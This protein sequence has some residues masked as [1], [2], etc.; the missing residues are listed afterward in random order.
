LDNV[1]CNGT[2]T[3]IVDCQHSGWG[4]NN[5]GYGEGVSVSCII[6]R[7]VGGPSPQEGRLEVRYKGTWG[8]VCDDHFDNAAASVVCH[9]L[10][11]K[12]TGQFIGSHYGAGNGTIWLDDIRCDGMERHISECSH[13]GWGNHNCGHDE[14]VAVSC[15]GDSSTVGPTIPT[16]SPDTML[17]SCMSNTFPSTH[18][19]STN[20]GRY[21]AQIVI[22]VVVVLGL[23]ICVIVIVLFLYFRQK[24]RQER[25]EVS[26]IPMPVTTSTNG[27]NNDAFDE[28]ALYED[29][30][31]NAQASGNNAYSKF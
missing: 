21:T 14:D 20:D 13:G 19:G 7:L 8:T 1:Q 12:H 4:N 30:A 5:C 26:M 6:V 27:H 10:G 17:L 23:I 18:S 3:N 22:T 28:T 16:S 31:D 2:E 24:L 25:T 11:Y 15:I 29:S 9:M